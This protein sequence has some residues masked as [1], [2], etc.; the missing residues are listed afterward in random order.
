MIGIQL[1]T[2]VRPYLQA[3][4]DEGVLALAAG[5]TVLRLRPPLVI[6]D[7]EVARVARTVVRVLGGTEA[8]G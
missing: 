5:S 8:G 3:L 2:Q 7:G 6:T 1:R 4:Q